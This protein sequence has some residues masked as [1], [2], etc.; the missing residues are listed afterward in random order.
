MESLAPDLF[1]VAAAVALSPFPIIP[2]VLLLLTGKPLANG[3]SFLAGWFGGLVTLAAVFTAAA[4]AVEFWDDE[5]PSWASWTRV[6]LGVVLIGLGARKWV[7]GGTKAETPSWMAALDGYTP[8]RAAK[9]GF[10]LAVANP[11]V[12]LLVLAGGVAIGAAELGFAA[13]TAAVLLFAAVA[14]STVALPVVLR[15]VGGERI[16]RPLDAARRWLVKHN[17]TIV[18]VVIIAIGVMLTVKG[19][20]GL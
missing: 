12:L 9:L 17:D 15:L 16:V 5:V 13:A 4:S 2:V 20:G 6:V 11:K 14:A 3:G 10:L 7:R 18:A 8:P 1:P 19:A